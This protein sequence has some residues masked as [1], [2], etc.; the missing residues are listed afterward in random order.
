MGQAVALG[1]DL[2]DL[3]RGVPGR[4]IGR[5]HLFEERGPGHDAVGQGDEIDEELLFARNQ[6]ESHAR[7]YVTPR[8]RQR[9]IPMA[10]AGQRRRW[11]SVR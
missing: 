7:K 8:F 3:Q 11:T 4:G 2:F 9:N 10:S 1:L 6:S 5:Q